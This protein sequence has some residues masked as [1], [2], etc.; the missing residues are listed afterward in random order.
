MKMPINDLGRPKS[1][2]LVSLLNFGTGSRIGK[3]EVGLV[4]KLQKMAEC[5]AMRK[6]AVLKINTKFQ[7]LLPS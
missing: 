4:L 7:I 1:P 6:N 3:A 5:D 2:S